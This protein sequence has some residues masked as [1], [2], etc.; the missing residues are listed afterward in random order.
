[1]PRDLK[2]AKAIEREGFPVPDFLLKKEH[3]NSKILEDE[4]SEDMEI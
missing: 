1:M 3:I 2:L 4:K